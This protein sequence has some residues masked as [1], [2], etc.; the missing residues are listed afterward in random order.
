MIAAYNEGSVIAN[1]IAGVL[2]YVRNV[3]VCDDCSSDATAQA[4]LDAGAHVL[5]HP[6]NLGQGAALQTGIAYA[7]RQQAQYIITF[8]ADGQHDAREILPML[9]A[10][11][12]SG[13]DAVLGSRFLGTK[14]N[15]PFSRRLVLTSAL[16]YTRLTARIRLTDVHNGF[17]ALTRKFCEEFEFK[18]NRMAHASEI[19]DHI[20]AHKVRFIEHPVTIVY[21]EYSIRKGQRSSNAIRIL[22]ELLM[23][24]VS[25]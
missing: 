9:A 1:T 8:D 18:Q 6:I 5:S 11:K 20:A 7:L 4:A 12:A 3:V 17:R 15:I 21:T 14:T 22:M 19:L 2:P 10:L 25:K 13:V 16:L 23:G 24:R